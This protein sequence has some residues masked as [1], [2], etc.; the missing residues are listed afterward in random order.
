LT[1]KEFSGYSQDG[2]YGVI[3]T[4]NSS[5]YFF[6]ALT[7]P[8]GPNTAGGK[9]FVRFNQLFPINPILKYTTSHEIKFIVWKGRSNFIIISH[10]EASPGREIFD[11]TAT[12]AAGTAA[13][14]T[15]SKTEAELDVGLAATTDERPIY[16]TTMQPLKVRK[17]SMTDGQILVTRELPKMI[18]VMPNFHVWVTKVFALEDSDYAVILSNWHYFAIWNF[19]DDT[20]P[21]YINHGYNNMHDLVVYSQARYIAIGSSEI[22]AFYN[23]DQISCRDPLATKCVAQNT[24]NSVECRQNSV[25]QTID[26]EGVLIRKCY[27]HDSAPFYDFNTNTCMFSV[28]TA[29]P[30]SLAET[31][32]PEP[33]HRTL[34]CTQF[35]VLDRFSDTCRCS[36]GSYLD[37]SVTPNKCVRCDRYPAACFGPGDDKSRGQELQVIGKHDTRHI[38]G[39]CVIESSSLTGFATIEG[40]NVNYY[41]L[42]LSQNPQ[43]QHKKYVV[44]DKEPVTK[45]GRCMHFDDG[46]ILIGSS[47]LRK[48]SID[49]STDDTFEYLTF[50]GVDGSVFD[51]MM[52]IPESTDLWIAQSDPINPTT[53]PKAFY[54]ID[55][56]N[57]TPKITYETL[58]HVTAIAV[59]LERNWIAV[60]F[61]D[62]SITQRQFFDHSLTGPVIS[63]PLFTYTKGHSFR[64]VGI[65]FAQYK[66]VYVVGYSNIAKTL[67]INTDNSAIQVVTFPTMTK[68]THIMQVPN[69]FYTLVASDENHLAITPYFETP[70]NIPTEIFNVTF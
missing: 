33:G 31:C 47:I 21:V 9:E 64:E 8:S 70:V 65:F 48:L 16:F 42:T 15:H 1:E 10:S 23:L 59:L 43:Y 68:I 26:V 49:P 38:N 39:V 27:C 69:S 61:T 37:D 18:D 35:A 57:L 67:D 58:G 14:S 25:L 53:T 7:H 5:I 63:S 55:S 12:D 2:N 46:K 44:L 54:R 17:H 30:D 28:P 66:P 51:I 60:S 29:C 45:S 40:N 13:L 56:T 24:E 62:T 19:E 32:S 22:V 20:T 6:A 41:E 34:T 50:P 3:A 52:K 11:A 36:V 4:T